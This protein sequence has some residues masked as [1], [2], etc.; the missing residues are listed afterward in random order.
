MSSA[1]QT[2][3]SQGITIS[4]GGNSGYTPSSMSTTSNII[5]TGK[6]D[7]GT[8]YPDFETLVGSSTSITL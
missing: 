2:Y 1:N 8:I 7:F 4:N 3:A 5:T 6:V